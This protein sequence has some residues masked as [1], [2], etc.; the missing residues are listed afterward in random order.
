MW[1]KDDARTRMKAIR[2]QKPVIDRE[3]CEDKKTLEDPALRIQL[4]L[5]E[6]HLQGGGE[7]RLQVE[8]FVDSQQQ[9][10]G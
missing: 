7:Q 2:A 10:R 1:W 6:D 4:K 3:D 8:L 9:E 5:D